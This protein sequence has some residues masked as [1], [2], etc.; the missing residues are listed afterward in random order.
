MFNFHKLEA[1]QE[2]VDAVDESTSDTDSKVDELDV[3]EDVKDEIKDIIEEA[4]GEVVETIEEGEAASDEVDETTTQLEETT[5]QTENLM[6]LYDVIEKHGLSAPIL[7]L[8]DANGSFR[9]A[10]RS[11]N[12]SVSFESLTAT[13]SFGIEQSV[14]L[15]TIKESLSNAWETTKKIIAKIIIF[16]K[17]MANKVIDVFRNKVS[18]V[19]SLSKELTE[20][21]EQNI[22]KDLLKFSVNIDGKSFTDACNGFNSKDLLTHT[23][24]LVKDF[25]TAKIKEATDYDAYVLKLVSSINSALPESCKYKYENGK[26]SWNPTF[27]SSYGPSKWSLKD[28]QSNGKKMIEFVKTSAGV[29][30][31]LVAYTKTIDALQKKLETQSAKNADAGKMATMAGKFSGFISRFIQVT[32]KE[33]NI[34]VNTYITVARAYLNAYKKKETK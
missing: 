15:E 34:V 3:S 9:R 29:K 24:S 14:A 7:A 19:E 21:K 27:D 23:N 22:D 16:I 4:V 10:C 25:E 2:E 8:C 28:A 32:L 33:M 31:E 12:S 6:L 17:N 26:L 30:P 20:V 1:I 18:L 5:E 11:N 13:P